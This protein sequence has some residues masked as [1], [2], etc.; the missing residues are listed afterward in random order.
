M[1]DEKF[2]P[3]PGFPKYNIS[4]TGTILNANTLRSVKHR[5][6]FQYPK[7]S[8]STDDGQ[9]SRFFH[10][11]VALAFVPNPENKTIVN[12]KDGNPLNCFAGNLEWTTPSEN[13]QHSVD[14]GLRKSTDPKTRVIEQ[15]DPMSE[16]IIAEFPSAVAAS[17]DLQIDVKKLREVLS[18]RQTY[19]NSLW[20]IKCPPDEE[21]EEWRE[22]KECNGVP[23]SY[24]RYM[25]SSAGK[26][27]NDKTGQHIS[28]QESSEGY[29]SVSLRVGTKKAR[30]FLI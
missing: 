27:K 8:L 24:I 2:I 5:G 23:L 4:K 25:V 21:G 6:G 12:H 13:V 19:A 7:V 17:R 3:I 28:F 11:M 9:K 15:V 29:H 16:T 14:T 18:S 1:T 26:V 30:M 20:R 22:V 10:R